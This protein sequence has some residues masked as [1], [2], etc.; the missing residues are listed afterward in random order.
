MLDKTDEIKL[1]K[2]GE[3]I[4]RENS[5]GKEIYIIMSG[6]VEISREI[7]GRKM[8]V[9]VLESGEFFGEMAP[10]TNKLR[11]A[12]ATA[13]GSVSLRELSVEDMIQR[14]HVDRDFMVSVI[15]RL[16]SRLRITTG[17]RG[18][19]D[20]KLYELKSKLYGDKYEEIPQPEQEHLNSWVSDLRRMV[21]QRDQQIKDLEYQLRRSKRQFLEYHQMPWYRKLFGKKTGPGSFEQIKDTPKKKDD[22]MSEGE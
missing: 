17:E 2:D 3:V 12:T 22:R 13:I 16:I 10:I 11:S 1:Y 8:S 7:D 18:L 19:L 4:F 20:K 14:M 15:E 21:D 9:A 6:E 5:S